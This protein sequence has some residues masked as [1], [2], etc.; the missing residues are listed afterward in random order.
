L[1]SFHS[2]ELLYHTF[3]Y[4]S[5]PFLRFAQKFMLFS[6][7][8]ASQYYYMRIFNDIFTYFAHLQAK[9]CYASNV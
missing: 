6:F 8:I 4:L 3:E 9:F 1:L 7:F 5:T 2:Q